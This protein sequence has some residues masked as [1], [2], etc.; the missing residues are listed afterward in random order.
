MAAKSCGELIES[1]ER[2]VTALETLE[3]GLSKSLDIDG[4][5]LKY[6]ISATSMAFAGASASATTLSENLR[7]SS[8]Y[9]RAIET[10][11]EEL[12]A[13]LRTNSLSDS[14]EFQLTM[15]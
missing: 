14:L 9:Y 5:L 1:D 2:D 12:G 4:Y 6:F 8:D 13:R 7:I 10:Q 11:G 15:K 3:G